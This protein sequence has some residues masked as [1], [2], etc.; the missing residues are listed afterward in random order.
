MA[1]GPRSMQDKDLLPGFWHSF[2]TFAAGS[3]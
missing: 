3:L 1:Y 2:Q